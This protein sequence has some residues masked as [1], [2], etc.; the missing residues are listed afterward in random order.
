MMKTQG[1]M[2]RNYNQ[3]TYHMNKV[4]EDERNEIKVENKK[5]EREIT[6]VVFVEYTHKGTLVKNLQ[7][8]D[9]EMTKVFKISRTK[10]V[11]RAGTKLVNKLVVKDPFYQLNGGCGRKC[12]ICRSQKGKGINCRLEGVTYTI[13]CAKCK[14]KEDEMGKKALYIGETGRSAF[15]RM[16]EHFYKFNNKHKPH[17]TINKEKG[18]D[19]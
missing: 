2:I 19:D 6:G 16:R 12:H 3:W 14:D 15:E 8:V 11:E 7:R 18:D 5:D 13:Q 10:Y 4:K 9:D 1:T 17:G